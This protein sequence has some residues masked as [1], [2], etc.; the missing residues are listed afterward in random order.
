MRTKVKQIAPFI[1][2]LLAFSIINSALSLSLNPGSFFKTSESS[3]NK[4]ADHN[5]ASEAQLPCESTENENR[6]ESENDSLF[7]GPE[8][9]HCKYIFIR[10][11]S[12]E[13]TTVLRNPRQ[14]FNTAC[15]EH[16]LVIHTPL[17]LS[18][19]VILV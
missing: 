18:Y 2:I 3:V 17:Y 15:D 16:P 19:R 6:D 9:H 11:V 14:Q 7:S 1:C 12:Q 8:K 10:T 5:S 4:Q 13:L